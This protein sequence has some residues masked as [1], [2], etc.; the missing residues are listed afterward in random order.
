VF[1]AE[2][3]VKGS[4]EEKEVVMQKVVV[5]FRK[6]CK[7]DYNKKFLSLFLP[8]LHTANDVSPVVAGNYKG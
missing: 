8:A 1:N 5:E 4:A 7:F 3:K 6:I 2:M